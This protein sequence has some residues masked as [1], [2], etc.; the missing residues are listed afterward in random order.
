M[1][2]W[3]E[4]LE[5]K[6]LRRIPS[7]QITLHNRWIIISFVNRTKINHHTIK[8]LG[9]HLQ[10]D[11]ARV[12]LIR[13][14]QINVYN[15]TDYDWFRNE[16]QSYK[17]SEVSHGVPWAVLHRHRH[18]IHQHQWISEEEVNLFSF[19]GLWDA[20][21]GPANDI[22]TARWPRW[23]WYQFVHPIEPPRTFTFIL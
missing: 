10:N 18:P 23:Q 2:L 12:V 9:I 8:F 3:T 20:S 19:N 5:L 6:S 22:V 21:S 14:S 11:L 1:T 15:T 17:A 4:N 7:H 16:W 13:N